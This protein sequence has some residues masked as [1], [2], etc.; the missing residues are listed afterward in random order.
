[1]LNRPSH[2][3]GNTESKSQWYSAVLKTIGATLL[4][5][6]SVFAQGQEISDKKISESIQQLGH[7]E[8]DI[9]ERAHQVLMKDVKHLS[10]FK[11]MYR[12]WKVEMQKEKEGPED[13]RH[14]PERAGRLFSLTEEGKKVH[15]DPHAKFDW[16]DRIPPFSQAFLPEDIE[17]SVPFNKGAKLK[18]SEILDYY[19]TK[20]PP[21]ESPEDLLEFIQ[22]QLGDTQRWRSISYDF[23]RTMNEDALDM[24]LNKKDFPRAYAT[25]ME[26]NQSLYR[27]KVIW[28]RVHKMGTGLLCPPLAILP[29]WRP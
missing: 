20:I 29:D 1:M 26:K 10:S 18:R 16:G 14:D 28:D 24:A 13:L 7:D 11:Q 3:A 22:F 21:S 2:L 27:R 8:F 9:R 15:A 6:Q 5:I 25:E 19:L 12:A 17:L 4:S 23:F